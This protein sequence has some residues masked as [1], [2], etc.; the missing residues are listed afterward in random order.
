MSFTYLTE[1]LQQN[2]L[3]EWEIVF[4]TPLESFDMFIELKS[5]F[6]S[7]YQQQIFLP[8]QQVKKITNINKHKTNIKQTN[9]Q[10]NI[11]FKN[12]E[13]KTRRFKLQKF[14]TFKCFDWF[15]SCQKIS[16]STWSKNNKHEWMENEQTQINEKMKK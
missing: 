6:V 5:E 14:T 11:A 13:Y 4:R 2:T 8:K 7:N 16:W 9:K 12:I 3:S 15:R 1:K 10:T